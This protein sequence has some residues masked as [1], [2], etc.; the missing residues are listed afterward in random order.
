MF[1]TF[2]YIPVGTMNAFATGAKKNAVIGLSDGILRQLNLQELAGVLA[3]EISHIRHNDMRVMSL[4][5]TLGLLTRT[6]SIMGQIILVIF[7]PHQFGKLYFLNTKLA[8][9]MQGV[10]PPTIR[11]TVRRYSLILTRL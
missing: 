5:D 8:P 9:Q 7:I 1:F 6:L 11:S 4:A 2:H 3:H 10:E